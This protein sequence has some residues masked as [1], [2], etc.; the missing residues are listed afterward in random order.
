[1]PENF[2]KRIQFHRKNNFTCITDNQFLV[3]YLCELVEHV[4]RNCFFKLGLLENNFLKEN[5]RDSVSIR[6]YNI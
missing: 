5:I 2:S 1:M 3:H 4:V 6:T